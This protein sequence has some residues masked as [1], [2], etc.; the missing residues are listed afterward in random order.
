MAFKRLLLFRESQ[1][2]AAPENLAPS[3]LLYGPLMLT[4]K[5]SD[6]VRVCLNTKEDTK[7][8]FFGGAGGLG[9]Q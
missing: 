9:E 3:L 6:N 7:R 2:M 1:L 5:R 8:G 4:I